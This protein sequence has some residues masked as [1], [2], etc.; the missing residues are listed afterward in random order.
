MRQVYLPVHDTLHYEAQIKPGPAKG[1]RKLRLGNNVEEVGNIRADQTWIKQRE[2][3]TSDLR[4]SVRIKTWELE[5][6]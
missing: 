1:N 6:V 2:I 4:S 3:E 5:Q